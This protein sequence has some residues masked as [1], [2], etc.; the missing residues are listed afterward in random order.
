[1][2]VLADVDMHGIQTSGNCIRNITSDCFAGVAADEIVDPR[3]YC[4]I[5]RQ[6]ST[7]HPEFAFLPR[8]FKIAVS[9]ASEDRAATAWHDIGLRP[10]QERRRRDRLPGAGRRRHGPHA[11]HR[12]ACCASSCRGSEILVYIEAIVRVYNRYGRRD[13]M[14]KARIKILVKAEGQKFIDAVEAEFAEHPRARRRRLGAPAPATPSSTAS[15]R[16]S[17][18]PRASRRVAETAGA[19]HAPAASKPVAYARWLERNVARAPPRRATAR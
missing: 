1:M 4:E 2:D 7:L 12:H 9:G 8:K 3:P 10:A 6:W 16:S 13:N 18:C 19:E 15:R 5:L 11:G 14:Y 17:R